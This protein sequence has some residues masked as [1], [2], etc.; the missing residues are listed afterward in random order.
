MQITTIADQIFE[1]AIRSVIMALCSASS[2]TIV[3]F[4]LGYAAVTVNS[5]IKHIYEVLGYF[6]ISLSLLL[7][8]RLFILIMPFANRTNLLYF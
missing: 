4:S 8:N 2:A 5:N 6:S 1:P 3:A 7:E